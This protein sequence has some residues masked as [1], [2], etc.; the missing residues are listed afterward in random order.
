[1]TASISRIIRT[2]WPALAAAW[3]APMILA[4]TWIHPVFFRPANPAESRY[5]LLLHLGVPFACACVAVLLWRI[6]RILRLFR[7]GVPAAGTVT[8]LR[9]SKDR[10]RLEF[11]YEV[12]G[13]LHEAWQPVQQSADVLALEPGQEVAVLVSPDDP[14]VAI[15]RHLF[16]APAPRAA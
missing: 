13:T 2:D 15:I 14:S 9:L 4:I 11:S 16:E 3:G 10:G 6:G 8:A 1:M 12:N 5:W 7:R